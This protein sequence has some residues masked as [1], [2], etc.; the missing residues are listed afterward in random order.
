MTVAKSANAQYGEISRPH[1]RSSSAW[2]RD[3]RT[4]IRRARVAESFF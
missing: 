2:E 1:P 3:L 4:A